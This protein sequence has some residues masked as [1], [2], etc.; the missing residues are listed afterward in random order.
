MKTS[1][2]ASQGRTIPWKRHP[3]WNKGSFAYHANNRKI[4]M[5]SGTGNKGDVMGCGVR[6]PKD[7]ERGSDSE[8]ER[9][10]MA[11]IVEGHFQ[12]A[13]STR[14]SFSSDQKKCK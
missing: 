7:F 2:S 14:R 1:S 6:F 4:F 8:E 5:G 11:R 9:E 12:E 3:G 13:E 10:L